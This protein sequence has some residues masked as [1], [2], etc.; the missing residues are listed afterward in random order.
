MK[1]K[2][3]MAVRLLVAAG[4]LLLIAGVIF[5]FLRQWVFAALIWVGAFSCLVAALNFKNRKDGK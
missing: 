3:E 1:E 5:G 2:M 4:I